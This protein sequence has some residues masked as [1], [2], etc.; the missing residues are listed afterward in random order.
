MEQKKEQAFV[1]IFVVVAVGL[2][3]A[4]IFAI[5]G[6]ASRSGQHFETVFKNAGGLEPGSIV[7]YAGIRVGRVEAVT[8]DPKDATRIIVHMGV[9]AG[10]PVKTDSLARIAS[11]SALGENFLE[12]MP[13]KAQSPL[14]K[15]G[16]TLPSKEAFGIGDVADM[17]N[18]LGPNVQDLVTN[19]N[20]RVT[21][22]QT[23][24]DRTNDL[25]NDPN[26]AH[27]ASSLSN[28]DGM[29]AENRPHIK[30]ALKNVDDLSA[31]LGP[32]VDQF[33]ETAKQADDTIKKLDDMLGENRKEL[34][35]SLVQLRKT[36]A[37][38]N[39]LVDNLNRTTVTNSENIDE[40]LD[41]IRLATENLREFTDTIRQRPS[42]L[43]R[44]TTPP[45]HKPGGGKP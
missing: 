5:S 12:I 41:N 43:I 31:K 44:S 18:Q 4:T 26:R 13:G 39:T 17:L 37:D 6:L 24:L 35:E 30:S 2:L 38:A 25:L 36:L 9:D 42:T 29:L 1:G 33:K 21:Q 19:L 7:R 15:T 45:E 11:V 16:A 28:L 23:T 27:V 20:G 22:L 14:A 8:I 3:I 34:H 32:T 10:V 40:M